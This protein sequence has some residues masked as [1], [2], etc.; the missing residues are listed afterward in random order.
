MAFTEEQTVS[1][2]AYSACDPSPAMDPKVEILIHELIGRVASKWTMIVLEV[3][4]KRAETRF[5]RLSELVPGISY[6]MLTQTLRQ[7]ERKG[8][9]HRTVYPVIP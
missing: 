3:L 8:L 9:V 1:T 7:M 2:L 5:T 4:A 6:K